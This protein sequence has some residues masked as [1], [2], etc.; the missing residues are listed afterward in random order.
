MSTRKSAQ[1]VHRPLVAQV[2]G[3]FSARPEASRRCRTTM[4]A[5]EWVTFTDAVKADYE[6]SA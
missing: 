6:L 2:S 3:G 1:T 5:A 4:T